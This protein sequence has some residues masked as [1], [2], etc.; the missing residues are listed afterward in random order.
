MC[1]S[2]SVSAYVCIFDCTHMF[3]V[4]AYEYTGVSI[5]MHVLVCM[6]L[7]CAFMYVFALYA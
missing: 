7:K 2:T 1:A 6:S 3:I 5:C 4:Y